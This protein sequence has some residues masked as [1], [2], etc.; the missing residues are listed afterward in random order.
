MADGGADKVKIYF[1][2]YYA[3]NF[4]RKVQHNKPSKEKVFSYL[5]KLD[6]DFSY[7]L[8]NISMDTLVKD[9]FIE[10]QGDGDQESLFFVK[11]F[12]EV[13]WVLIPLL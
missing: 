13:K 10:V 1:D 4:I 9:N 6:K 2:I 5:R 12:D 8:F 3:I 7:D 11:E